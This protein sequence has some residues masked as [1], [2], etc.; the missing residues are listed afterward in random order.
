M[1]GISIIIERH[2]S[3]VEGIYSI[4]NLTVLIPEKVKANRSPIEISWTIVKTV[5]TQY[6]YIKTVPP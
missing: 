2:W 1:L 5:G 4:V 6:M 3:P